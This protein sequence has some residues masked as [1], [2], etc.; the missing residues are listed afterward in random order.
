MDLKEWAESL[1]DDQIYEVTIIGDPDTEE[2]QAAQR[3]Y[4]ERANRPVRKRAK[5]SK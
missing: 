5:E 3:E 2:W 1:T 4:W